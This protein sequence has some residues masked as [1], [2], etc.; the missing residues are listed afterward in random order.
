M[1]SNVMVSAP[2]RFHPLGSQ[3]MYSPPT[4]KLLG[5]DQQFR[6]TVGPPE[7]ALAV[8]VLEPKVAETPRGTVIVLHGIWNSSFWMLGTAKMLSEEGYRAVLVDLRGH[9]ASTGKWLTYGQR[10]AEDISQVID[11]L[12]E[13]DLV[14]GSLGVYGISYGATTSIHL[15]GCDPRIETVVAVAPF[16]KMRDEVPDYS[17]TMLPGIERLVSDD[18][19]QQAVAEAGTQGGFDP[20]LSDAITAIERTS[21]RVLIMH[22]TN[23][24]LVPPYHSL[25]LY[26]AGRA[27][28]ELV[29]LPDTGHISIWF[30]SDDEVATRTKQWFDRWLAE[31]PRSVE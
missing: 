22:G 14:V 11:E 6:V 18:L 29:Y 3:S 13:R 25:R 28:S 16:S 4:R 9:G 17:R 21:A 19:I 12:E 27:H 1:L 8:T 31:S 24:W 7:A 26:E 30:D 20:E 23:D 10:E 15:A 5:I 2:N